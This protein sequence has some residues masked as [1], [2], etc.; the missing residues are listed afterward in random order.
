[1]GKVL[2]STGAAAFVLV[3]VLGGCASL[4][5]GPSDQ[6]LI[7]QVVKN[8]QTDLQK[9]DVDAVM[10]QF[11]SDYSDGE[12][13]DKAGLKD[14]L[15][16]A[17]DQ[18]YLDDIEVNIDDMKITINDDTATAGPVGLYGNFGGIDV[19]LGLKEE[20]EGNWLITSMDEY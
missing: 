9:G 2:V 11:S 8:Y 1:M 14:F 20:S 6:E 13:R 17:K 16:Q 4:K 10:T 3:T 5:K 12:G 15:N 7:T 19:T 18:G